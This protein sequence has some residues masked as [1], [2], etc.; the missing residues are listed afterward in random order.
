MQY[1]R[2]VPEQPIHFTYTRNSRYRPYINDSRMGKL[3]SIAFS[4]IS[5]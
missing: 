2:P 3:V 1:A 5:P 4:P